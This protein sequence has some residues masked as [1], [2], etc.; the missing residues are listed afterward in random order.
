[1]KPKNA[2]F[3]IIVHNKEILLFLRDDK[4]TIPYPNHWQLPGG[5]LEKGE[6]PL[7]GLMRE[8]E[9]E[10]SYIPTTIHKI[11]YMEKADDTKSYLYIA[12]VDD[13]EALKFKHGPG[14]GQMIKFFAQEELAKMNLVFSLEQYANRYPE[15]LNK[16]LNEHY[17]P[18][19]ND[20]G[21][22]SF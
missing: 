20:F 4:P 14:E 22:V 7:K 18:N 2:S 11:G 15:I 9:E 5:Q 10:V 1:M 6:T 3:A 19:S 8:L 16:I 21:L 17:I 13:K 12:I